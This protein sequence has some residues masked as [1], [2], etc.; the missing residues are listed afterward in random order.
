MGKTD[1]GRSMVSYLP[2]KGNFI[3][4]EFDP[5]TGHEQMGKRPGLVVSNTAFNRKMGFVFI[6]PITNTKRKNRFHVPVVSKTL[7]GYIMVD[8]LKSLDYRARK[9]QFIEACSEE[10]LQEVLSRIEPILF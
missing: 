10:L 8:Q 5:Q 3:S 4:L 9:A 1:G 6:C 7:T 2:K